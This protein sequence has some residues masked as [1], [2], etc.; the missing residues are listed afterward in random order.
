MAAFLA[1]ALGGGSQWTIHNWI[2]A[3]NRLK[4]QTNLLKN[5]TPS[6]IGPWGVLL[7]AEAVSARPASAEGAH[8]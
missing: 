7:E 3:F 8:A 2:T 4:K 6:S 1:V 5:V